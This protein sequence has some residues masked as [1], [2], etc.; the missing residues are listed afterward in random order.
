[1]KK[2]WM[3]RSLGDVAVVMATAPSLGAAARTLG[4]DKSSVFRWVKAGKIPPPGGRRQRGRAGRGASLPDR[5]VVPVAAAG[6]AAAIRGAYE[7]DATETELVQLAETALA[8][9][10][11]SAQLPAVRL[12]AMARFQSLTRQIDL[13]GPSDGEVATATPRSHA[14]RRVN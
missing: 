4:V 3:L 2:T 11:D 9:A 1:M 14:P 6:W 10:R 13:E 5:P 7:L 12:A 8:L